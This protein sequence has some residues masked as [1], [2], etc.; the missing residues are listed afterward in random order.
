MD[1]KLVQFVGLRLID[2]DNTH[3]FILPAFPQPL[4]FLPLSSLYR[5]NLVL[6]SISPY[7]DGLDIVLFSKLANNVSWA[8]DKHEWSW[9]FRK[10]TDEFEYGRHTRK[11]GAKQIKI[12]LTTN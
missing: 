2:H 1:R 10:T 12:T 8:D 3:D 11:V 9:G 5:C 7:K 6:V 4:S